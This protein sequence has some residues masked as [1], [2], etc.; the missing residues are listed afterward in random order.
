[1]I[2]LTLLYVGTKYCG[3]CTLFKSEWERVK[4]MVSNNTFDIPGVRLELEEHVVGSHDALS[5]ALQNTVSFYPFIMVLPTTY[6]RENEHKDTVLVGEA[7]YTYR[8]I[9]DGVLQ[10]RLGGSVN[11]SPN[12]RYPRTADGIRDWIRNCG[13]ESLQNLSAK[14]YDNMSFEVP[15]GEQLPLQ[16]RSLQLTD[17]HMDMFIPPLNKEYQVVPGGMVL[18]RRIMN[19]H[20]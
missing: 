16:M 7:M 8:T 9:K 5:P 18:C 14:H 13:L 10:Y 17:F 1:M 3:N 4:N 20:S 6:Y 12:M 11:D 2:N 15:V 19:V